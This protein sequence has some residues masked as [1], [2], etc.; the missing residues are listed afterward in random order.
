VLRPWDVDVDPDGKEPL[1]PFEG[2]DALTQGTI[3]AF[4]AI[5]PTYAELIKTMREI[6]HLDL[7]SRPGKMPGGYNY[8]LYETGVPFIFMNAVGSQ[9]D[10]VTMFHEGGHAIQ[11]HLDH[12]LELT[13]FKGLPSEVAELASMSMELISMDQWHLF[14]PNEDDLVRAKQ[15]QLK[16]ILNILP[17]I[18]QVDAFQH[19][20]YQ[21][22]DAG[23][24]KR[25]ETWLA[26]SKQ[27]G[28]G[29]TDWTGL[30]KFR[31]TSW[32]RQLHLFEVPFY[33]IEYGM[34]QLG[35]IAVWRNYRQDSK[36]ALDQYEAALALGYTQSIPKIYETAGVKF[37]FSAAYVR[38]LVEFVKKEL[39]KLQ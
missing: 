24:E 8:P 18:A 19:W 4:D 14:Y 28:T 39:A 12:T 38:E 17:W 10:L 9:G 35:A 27:F 29:L 25:N 21:N 13:S 20:V 11:S 22:F 36:Q 23:I 31:P 30:E 34:A 1:K 3:D 32:H 2:G 37:D 16:K 15:D 26:L 33:Y 6:G 5:R 7:D